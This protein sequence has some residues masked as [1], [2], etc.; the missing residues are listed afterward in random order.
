MLKKHREPFI[1]PVHDPLLKN[2]ELHIKREDVIHPYI[3]GNKWYKLKYNVQEAH[4]QGHDTLLTFGG[5]YSNHIHATSMAAK[6][7]GLRSIGIIRGEE[8][9]NKPLNKTLAFA[10][11]Q[12]MQLE[13]IDRSAYREKNTNEF[14][15]FLRQRFGQFYLVPEGGTN[16]LAVTGCMEIVNEEARRYDFVCCS[17]GTGGTVAGLIKGMQGMGHVLGFAAL[18]GDFL[19]DEVKKLLQN[20]GGTA[21]TNWDIITHYH[22]G[23]YAKKDPELQEF[24]EAFELAHS[25][26]LDPIYTGK[27]LYGLFDLAQ[28]GFF[29]RGSRVLAVH[30]GGLQGK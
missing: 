11:Q 25:I 19:K 15:Q 13:F 16:N 10:R 6:E 4:R 7:A 20:H 8:L 29:P 9:E 26:P 17:V 23:G 18:K 24:M 14:Q 28:K 22:F 12:G 1:Q 3:S 27:L 2:V 5:A 30:S 21:P